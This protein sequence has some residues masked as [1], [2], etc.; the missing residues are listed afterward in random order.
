[1]TADRPDGAKLLAEAR[2]TLLETL[3]PLLPADRRY[4]GLMI[5]NAMAIAARE[6][7]EQ[8]RGARDMLAELMALLP[9]PDASDVSQTPPPELLTRLEAHLAHDI[10]GGLYDADDDRRAAVAR[11]LLTATRARLRLSN[12]KL[13]A[14]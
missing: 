3:L 5:A 4:D 8:G 1:V 7:A 14:E 9:P 10:R 2:R 11:Y 12:P 13:V 6:L